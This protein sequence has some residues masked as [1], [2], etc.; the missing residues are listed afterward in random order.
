MKLTDLSAFID[1]AGQTVT[2]STREL[3]LDYRRGL[4]T[5]N[6]ARAQGASGF[7]KSAGAVETK[8]LVISSDLDLGHVVVVA[9]DDRPLT[10]SRRMLL[11]VMSEEKASGFKTEPVSANVQR[12]VSIGSDPWQVKEFSGAVKFKRSDA[13]QLKVQA[14]D[15]NGYPSSVIGGAHEIKLQPA[16]LYYLISR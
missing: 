3:K 15:F 14:L 2:S 8:D 1:H 4:L 13:A 7:L 10:A 6:A 5:I 12:I 11:Q 16:T 9:L